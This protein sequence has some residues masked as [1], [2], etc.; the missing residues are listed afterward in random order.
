MVPR[1]WCQAPIYVYI[2]IYMYG[3]LSHLRTM[4]LKD[5]VSTL[6]DNVSTLKDNVSTDPSLT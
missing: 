5:N 3:P 4:P 6:K 2:C 1:D